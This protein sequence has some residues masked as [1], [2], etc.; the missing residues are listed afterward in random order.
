MAYTIPVAALLF[1]EQAAAA[2]IN[3][4]ANYFEDAS[5]DRYDGIEAL[6][7]LTG[8]PVTQFSDE[9][10]DV[11]YLGLQIEDD[12]RIDINPALLAKATALKAQ[13]QHPL[14][15]AAELAVVS[16]FC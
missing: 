7:Q 5:N 6:Q 14:V 13:Y 9:D 12:W 1:D 4:P 8:A 16:Q 2:A 11:Y 3:E 10:G 15:Q